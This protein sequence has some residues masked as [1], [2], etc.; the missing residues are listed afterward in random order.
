MTNKVLRIRVDFFISFS[1][2]GTSWR[3]AYERRMNP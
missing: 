2:L 3:R 1:F